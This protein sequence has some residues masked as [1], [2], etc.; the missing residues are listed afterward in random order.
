VVPQTCSD[1]ETK[2][3]WEGNS[4]DA[5]MKLSMAARQRKQKPRDIRAIF[6]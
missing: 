2:A 3:K 5:N 4:Y 6:G 1:Y